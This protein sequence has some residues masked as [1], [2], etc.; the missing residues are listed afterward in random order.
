MSDSPYMIGGPSSWA[1]YGIEHQFKG[2]VA[3]RHCMGV[4][5]NEWPMFPELQPMFDEWKSIKL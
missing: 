3:F 5:R 1:G 2:R 4:K